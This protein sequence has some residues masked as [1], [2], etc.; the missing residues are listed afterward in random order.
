MRDRE[1]AIRNHFKLPLVGRGF[2]IAVNASGTSMYF[3]VDYYPEHWVYPYAG[4][5]ERPQSRWERDVD[6]RCG[7]RGIVGEGGIKVVVGTQKGGRTIWLAR[8]DPEILPIDQGGL[9]RWEGP[10]RA[11]CINSNV[12]WEYS[13]RIVR[14]LAGALGKH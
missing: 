11:Y 2:K 12:Y 9:K 13:Q 6:G 8:K 3:G 10:R 14:A 5:P 4:T 1:C 7:G